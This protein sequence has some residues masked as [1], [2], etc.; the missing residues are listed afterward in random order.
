MSVTLSVVPADSNPAKEVVATVSE[1]LTLV[2]GASSTLR[3]V[4]RAL[5]LT[6]SLGVEITRA[7]ALVAKARKRNGVSSGWMSTP[8]L[9]GPGIK[10]RRPVATSMVESPKLEKSK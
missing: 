2:N 4:P 8:L 1:A 5:S 10:V 6:N 7:L 3:S 9:P